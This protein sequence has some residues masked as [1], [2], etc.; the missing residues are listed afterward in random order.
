MILNVLDSDSGLIHQIYT[1]ITLGPERPSFNIVQF[2]NS[3]L[4]V[5]KNEKMDIWFLANLFNSKIYFKFIMKDVQ[6]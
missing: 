4:L 1:Q 3:R 5:T 6:Y 2:G